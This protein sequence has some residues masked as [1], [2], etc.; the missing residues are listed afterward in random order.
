[1]TRML[2]WP[3]LLLAA[4][5]PIIM[6][7]AFVATGV[8]NPEPALASHD[9]RCDDDTVHIDSDSDTTLTPVGVRIVVVL[10]V[11]GRCPLMQQEGTVF[12]V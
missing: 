5:L 9:A 3:R 7:A 12:S 6:V 1:M 8:V 4:T 10:A 11:R 2:T